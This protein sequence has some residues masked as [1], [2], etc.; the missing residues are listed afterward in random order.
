MVKK[1]KIEKILYVNEKS[2]VTLTPI[3]NSF[4]ADVKEMIS[5]T[6]EN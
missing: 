6:L 1:E 5:F 2:L 4:S 3:V